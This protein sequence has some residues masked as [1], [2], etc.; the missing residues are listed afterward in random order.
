MTGFG[1]KV[2]FCVFVSDLNNQNHNQ[3]DISKAQQQ[4]KQV[5]T[6]NN[7]NLETINNNNNNDQ[8]FESTERE[9]L[10]KNRIRE[11]AGT[12]EKVT[13]T[14]QIREKH[15]QAMINELNRANAVLM[16][17]LDS[18]KKKYLNRVKK[19]EDQIVFISE[20]HAAQMQLFNSNNR[21]FVK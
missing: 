10:L 3:N 8:S 5:D 15:N 2:G 19:M 13:A 14:S 7:R 20:R 17:T 1:L 4:N 16:Q 6:D 21:N 11:L 18:T 9:V 12:L